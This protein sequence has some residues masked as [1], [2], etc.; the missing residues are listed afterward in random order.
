MNKETNF[1]EIRCKKCN[2]FFMS[3]NIQGDD[4]AI[5]IKGIFMKCERCRR[6][7]TLK[8]YTEGFLKKH[9]VN[10]VFKI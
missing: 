4:E 10:G 6:A 3:Y 5:V 9:S 7:M 8:K 2:R 1:I